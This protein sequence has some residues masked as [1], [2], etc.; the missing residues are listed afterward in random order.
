MH[1]RGFPAECVVVRAAYEAVR[2]I[3]FA[4]LFPRPNCPFV[5]YEEGYP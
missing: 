5:D 2:E 1:V 4:S 3:T